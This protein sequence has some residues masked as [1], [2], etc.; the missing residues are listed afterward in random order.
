MSCNQWRDTNRFDSAQLDSC[1]EH[2]KARDFDNLGVRG[3]PVLCHTACTFCFYS[4]G[5]CHKGM[6]RETGRYYHT[7]ACQNRR[8]TNT[9]HTTKVPPERSVWPTMKR[10]ARMSWLW[11]YSSMSCRP[12]T[13][14]APSETTMSARPP[15]KS[16]ITCWA[17]SV[18]V[19]SPCAWQLEIQVLSE[20]PFETLYQNTRV[21]SCVQVA[22]TLNLGQTICGRNR[23]TS[24]E[25]LSLLAT[26]K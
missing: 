19:M 7:V 8:C 16:L 14:G 26:K 6:R 9:E 12:V 17:V 23:V 20:L 13:S 3:R 11:T 24:R 18:L 1:P 4:F 25:F 5:L 10:A 21:L 2:P 15:S 22:S